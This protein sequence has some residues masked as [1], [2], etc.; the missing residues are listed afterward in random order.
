MKRNQAIGVEMNL[1]YPRWQ[2]PLAAAIL[3][4]DPRRFRE[5]AQAA[6]EAIG[7]RLCE[8]AVSKDT[9]DELLALTDGASLIRSIKRDRLGSPSV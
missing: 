6:E 9:R 1:K 2:E 4:F 3:E 5:K 8:L 7:I